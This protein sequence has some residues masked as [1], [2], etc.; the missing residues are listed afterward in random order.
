MQWACVEI[1]SCGAAAYG[2]EGPGAGGASQRSAVATNRFLRADRTPSRIF[3]SMRLL[4]NMTAC[5][6]SNGCQLGFGT[7]V[8]GNVLS[9]VCAASG[10]GPQEWQTWKAEP[11]SAHLKQGPVS[12]YCLNKK[13][14]HCSISYHST[15]SHQLWNY[16]C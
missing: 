5:A 10:G 7:R 2:G 15:R 6:T 11:L 16:T 1:R 9:W 4:D 13:Y 14:I 3:T 8:A 12:G